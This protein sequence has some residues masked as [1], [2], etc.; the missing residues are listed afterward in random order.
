M[1]L[2]GLDT[3]PAQPAGKLPQ[4]FAGWPAWI[5]A[6]WSLI[7][8][9][10]VW[11]AVALGVAIVLY[12]VMVRI[13]NRL[14]KYLR[15]DTD[16]SAIWRTVLA[17]ALENT[18]R[19]F[20]AVVAIYCATEL[21]GILAWPMR[22]I[23]VAAV[24]VQSG[25]W[26]VTF[27]TQLFSWYARRRP[28]DQAS[29]A[30]AISLVNIIIRTAVWSVVVL[31]LL[32]NIGVDITALVAGLGIG[33]IAIGLA[34]QGIFSDLFASLSIIFDRP[35]VRGDFVVFGDSMGTIENVGIKSTRIRS[36]SGEQIVISN[37]NLLQ[38]TIH[39]YQRLYQRRI[40]FS[41]GVTYQTPVEKVRRI[42]QIMRDSIEAVEKTRCDR[43][44][45]KEFGD[46]ALTY[47]AVYFVLDP[48]YNIYMDV[49]QA[50]NFEL[51]TRFERE[52]IDFAYPTRTLMISGGLSVAPPQPAAQ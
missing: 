4:D 47:E 18:W 48:D 27:L 26:L 44:H 50:I 10:A 41:L 12:A 37:A 28:A 34:A 11:V 20:F 42:P 8:Y 45:F 31:A 6:N 29:L 30:N 9:W 16:D 24:L 49:Q 2:F 32:S 52:K 19:L 5:Q 3:P 46:S 23:A 36:L 33:G 25:L 22:E 39:N 1:N 35:F 14:L 21:L 40:V 43:C 7:L 51:M 13:R 15:S 17:N 38:S